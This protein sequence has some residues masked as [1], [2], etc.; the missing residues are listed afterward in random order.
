MLST[1]VLVQEEMLTDTP[2]LNGK[3]KFFKLRNIIYT[4]LFHEN[5][6]MILYSFSHKM[7]LLFFPPCSRLVLKY[8]EVI[9]MDL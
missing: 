3:P 9:Y 8:S 7:N 6:L 2:G 5:A 1:L 4:V